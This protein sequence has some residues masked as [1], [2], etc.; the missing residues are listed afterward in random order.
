ML[1]EQEEVKDMKDSKF[2]EQA[3]AWITDM[4]DDHMTG[5][6]RW[7]RPMELT[8]PLFAYTVTDDTILKQEETDHIIVETQANAQCIEAL[9]EGFRGEHK[10]QE[11]Q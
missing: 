3:A 7:M 6:V 1:D 4:T 9:T 5:I 8:S 10:G 11:G 2:S